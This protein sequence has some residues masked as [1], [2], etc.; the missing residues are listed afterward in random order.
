MKAYIIVKV[1]PSQLADMVPPRPWGHSLVFAR[2]LEA[3]PAPQHFT[4]DHPV[5]FADD[6]ESANGLAERLAVLR[7][8]THWVVAKS[9]TTFRS[10]PGPV[11][12]AAFSEQGLLPKF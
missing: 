7:P 10:A 1:E 3:S 8:G 6:E 9:A 12:R 2:A 11:T 5:Y 4:G